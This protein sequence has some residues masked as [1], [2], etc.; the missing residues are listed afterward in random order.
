MIV[1]NPNTALSIIKIYTQTKIVFE[2]AK[3]TKAGPFV[4]LAD[5]CAALVV[6]DNATFLLAVNRMAAFRQNSANQLY[7]ITYH[8]GATGRVS[9]S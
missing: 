1:Q 5:C 6:A 2:L 9:V 7:R 4:G 3:I 8:R